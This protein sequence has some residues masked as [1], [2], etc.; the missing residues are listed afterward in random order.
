[1]TIRVPAIV[2]RQS[3]P[4]VSLFPHVKA[5]RVRLLRDPSLAGS[6]GRRFADF[7]P[8][9]F[10]LF[11]VA[12]FL[13]LVVIQLAVA[14]RKSQGANAPA[15]AIQNTL[16]KY[17]T[18]PRAQERVSERASERVSPAERASEASSAEQAN[19]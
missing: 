1:M 19:E 18:I 17:S 10:A 14:T 7:T 12:A 15:T 11:A 9:I 16:K 13:S 3:G 4:S 2:S 6:T 8:I 5:V